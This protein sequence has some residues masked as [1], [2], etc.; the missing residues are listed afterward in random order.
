MWAEEY[1][2]SPQTFITLPACTI[3][4]FTVLADMFQLI[5]GLFLAPLYINA[6]DVA[7]DYYKLAFGEAKLISTFGSQKVFEQSIIR[8]DEPKGKYVFSCYSY[9]DGQSLGIF[10][11]LI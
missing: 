9:K 2:E 5:W 7:W 3:D 10:L 11:V 8:L 4:V 1:C 6:Q